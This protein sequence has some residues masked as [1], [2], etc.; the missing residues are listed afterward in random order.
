MRTRITTAIP[1][2]A[3]T[4]VIAF[5]AAGLVILLPIPAAGQTVSSAQTQTKPLDARY[6]KG[7]TRYTASVTVSQTTDLV[8]QKVKVS[9]SGLRPTT[10]QGTYPVVIMQCWGKAAEVTQQTCWN[11]GT[12]V[13]TQRLGFGL[14]DVLFNATDPATKAVFG[15]TPSENSVVPFKA[16]DDG[17][18]YNGWQSSEGWGKDA[19]GKD[20]VT[21]TNPTGF[22]VA[23]SNAVMPGTYVGR[24][25]AN[26]SGE[27]DIELLTEFELKHLGCGSTSPCSLVVI[28]V[29]DPHCNASRDAQCLSSASASLRNATTWMWPTN[30]SRRV[31]FDLSFRESPEACKLDDRLETGLAGSWYAYQLL[32]NSWRPKFCNDENLFKLGYTALS[33]GDARG[34]FG[35]ALAS[36]WQDGSTNAL[37]TSRAMAGEPVKPF[38]YAPVTVSSVAVSFILDA[39]DGT[40]EVTELKL[41][42]RL[43]AKLFTQSYRT[44]AAAGAEHP[45]L[46][47]NPKWWGAD[48][49]F[50]ALNPSL[51]GLA[52]LTREGSEY[53]VFSIGDM[54]ALYALTAYIAA[55]KDAVAWLNGA[56]DGYG[57]F[58]NPWYHHYQLPVGL[59]ELRDD[60]VVTDERSPFKGEK[61]LGQHANTADNINVGAVAATQAWPTAF[62]NR[63][64]TP[65]P[66]PAKPPTC[67]F[68]RKD[69][70]QVG[71]Q[72][73]ML[74]VTSLGDSKVYG[75]RQAALQTAAGK[76][77]APDDYSVAQ[78]LRGT[79]LDEKT[80][81][82][83]TDFEKLH[84]DAYPGMS[85]VY[86]GIPTTGLSPATA[87][88][89]AK[90][91][92]YAAE[93]GQVRGYAA[94]QLPDGYVPLSEPLREQTRNAAKAVREQKG[95][96]PPPPASLAED[97]AAGLLPPVGGGGGATN[98]AAGGGGAGA[99]AP[100][101]GASPSASPTGAPTVD[102][103]ATSVATRTDSSGLAKWVLPGLL[104]IAVLAGL[105]AFGAMVW[106]QPDHP[107]RRALRAAADRLRRS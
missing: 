16:R 55:D 91:L 29:G 93:P 65:D 57:M 45:A 38:V 48:P 94:G 40:K 89:Y 59:L 28:P 77:V 61:L 17:L 60:W 90:F 52:A 83:S 25:G 46:K 5:L 20:K 33:D 100:A 32:N 63:S 105:I 96:V 50:A 34:L 54:D 86:A 8:H 99:N 10:A 41:N 11:A 95:E 26:G 47:N 82:L 98:G 107:V 23:T 73:A 51:A 101:P 44:T 64:C 106:T 81:V 68:K 76:F 24:T 49:E 3:L 92:D 22:S 78:A 67:V 19:E 102:K 87:G 9:W 85:I 2:L 1:W 4:N 62:I 42:A 80:G 71:G 72:R 39:P 97:P 31:A 75:L 69:Q 36:T 104:A 88:N 27:H 56:N 21:K 6:D 84:P 70:R 35:T 74:A 58:V 37:L 43:L 7:G 18:L 12:N 30:W 53:P 66:D 79:K 14:H 13:G 103:A 15:D